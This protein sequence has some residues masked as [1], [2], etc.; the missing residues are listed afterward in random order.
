VKGAYIPLLRNVRHSFPGIPPTSFITI[1][2]APRVIAPPVL[3]LT[4][5]AVATAA[6]LVDA[7]LCFLAGEA[8]TDA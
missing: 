3:A 6:A 7:V 5:P 8:E 1:V 2:E 4:A